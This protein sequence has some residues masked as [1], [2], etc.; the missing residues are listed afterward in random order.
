MAD[1]AIFHRA[2]SSDP[3]PLAGIRSRLA[4]AR[5]RAR[6]DLLIEGLAWSLAVGLGVACAA[7]LLQWIGGTLDPAS[8]WRN[9]LLLGLAAFGASSLAAAVRALA[10]PPGEAML[11]RRA[12]RLFAFDERLSTA[13]EI[14][15]ARSGGWAATLRTAALAEA[16]QRAS[17]IDPKILSPLKA[18]SALW[19]VLALALAL[20]ALTLV[21]P[22]SFMEL[23]GD[24]PTVPTVAQ[25]EETAA[26]LR[27]I[28]E[29]IRAELSRPDGYRAAIA[30]TLDDA[31]GQYLAG[32]TTHAELTEQLT[33]LLDHARRLDS[34]PG[35]PALNAA[36]AAEIP[37]LI[38]AALNAHLEQ[39]A[40]PQ[41]APAEDRLPAPGT[42]PGGEAEAGN[43]EGNAT[44][45]DGVKAMDAAAPQTANSS[46]FPEAIPGTTDYEDGL[47]GLPL[48]FKFE[49]TVQFAA[50][51]AGGAAE[52]GKGDG[53]AIGRGV[54]PLGG[55]ALAGR[56]AFSLL[57]AMALPLE[58]GETGRRIRIEVDPQAMAATPGI[59]PAA[60]AWR[61]TPAEAVSRQAIGPEDRAIVARYFTHD[62]AIPA[63]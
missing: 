38:E 28:A 62:E 46:A 36:S 51:P 24:V 9:S 39:L 40:Q 61:S 42:Q 43:G 2:D 1:V 49:N 35:M 60:G 44:N 31:A 56:D 23:Q 52:A 12:D 10:F 19:A 21:P 50:V 15:G 6:I 3:A 34:A 54:M 59:A 37:K 55:E 32:T 22:P 58:A 33:Q 16:G 18:P 53:D 25:R 47:A 45:P 30:R 4:D 5:L 26:N 17:A 27:Q 14:D 29:T 57:E 11:A 41:T 13:L 7:Y 63:P 8:P 48:D 20:A